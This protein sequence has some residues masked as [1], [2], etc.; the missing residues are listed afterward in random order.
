MDSAELIKIAITVVIATII[1][2]LVTFA[3]KHSVKLAIKLKKMSTIIFAEK[4]P[5]FLIIIDTSILIGIGITLFM[6]IS[7]HKLV[8]SS[9]AVTISFICLMWFYWPSKLRQD[10]E[11]Y[12]Q[13]K[14]EKIKTNNV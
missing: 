13:A 8:T 4:T 5:I 7:S 6:A 14:K 10:I 11:N 2:E 9:E 3:I 1:R 12:K